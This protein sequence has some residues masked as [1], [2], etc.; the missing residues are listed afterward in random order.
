MSFTLHDLGTAY[1]KAKVDLLEQQNTALKK[2]PGL[3][4]KRA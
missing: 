4:P 3:T 1:R 2:P